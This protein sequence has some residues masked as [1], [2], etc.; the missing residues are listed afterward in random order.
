M[1]IDRQQFLQ[2]IKLRKLVRRSVKV[3]LEKKVKEKENQVLEEEKFRSLV[4]K[5]ILSETRDTGPGGSI[6]SKTYLNFLA[7]LMNDIENTISAEYFNLTSRPEQRKSLIKNLLIGIDGI[8]NNLKLNAAADKGRLNEGEVEDLRPGPDDD[9]GILQTKKE[10]KKSP[11]DKDQEDMDNFREPTENKTGG[12]IAYKLLN[13]TNIPKFIKQ[14][15][16]DLGTSD[17]QEKFHLY[18]KKNIYAKA[19]E[20][21]EPE[22]ATDT[23]QNTEDLYRDDEFAPIIGDL[24]PVEDQAPAPEEDLGGLGL[25]PI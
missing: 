25:P 14:Y 21:W 7:S 2:E 10:P 24:D 8:I 6:Y 22:V 1:L 3:L 11:E 23:G 5:L 13:K 15:W 4:R 19:K 20:E 16:K 17:E 9:E 12:N 18:L